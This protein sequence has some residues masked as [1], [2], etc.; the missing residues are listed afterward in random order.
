MQLIRAEP[1]VASLAR[2]EVSPQQQ[3]AYLLGSTVFY[4][5]AYYSGLLAPGNP[6][7]TTPSVLEG[8]ALL[9]ISI[10]G[11]VKCFDASG[12]NGNQEFL[13]EFTCLSLPVSVTTVLAGWLAY[14]ALAISFRETLIELSR[15]HMEFAVNL[16][17]LNTDF[18][19]LLSFL[20]VVGIQFVFYARLSAL[21]RRV[22]DAKSGA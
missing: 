13:S 12:G 11:I 17:R 4:L 18:F 9:A 10:F 20:A 5:F 21:L 15:S 2:R 22:R 16:S 3:A 14:W 1:L 7:W 19:G 8:L 6:P